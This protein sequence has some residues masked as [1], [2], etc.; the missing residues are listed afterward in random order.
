MIRAGYGKVTRRGAHLFADF[1]ATL[2]DVTYA[3]AAKIFCDGEE[4]SMPMIAIAA[5]ISAFLHFSIAVFQLALAA[6]KP[7]GQFSWGGKHAGVLPRGFR[8]GSI[9]SFVVLCLFAAVN[10]QTAAIINPVFPAGMHTVM[11]W[12]VTVYACLGT[13]MNAISRSRGERLLWTPVAALLFALNL[14]ILLKN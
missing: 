2:L 9:F 8:I 1:A 4:L 12:I 7:W 11:Q 5:L 14:L 13:L 10:L 3:G 6:G